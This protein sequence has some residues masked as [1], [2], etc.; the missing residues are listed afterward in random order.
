MEDGIWDASV[1]PGVRGCVWSME[2]CDDAHRVWIADRTMRSSMEKPVL[3]ETIVVETQ[4]PSQQPS[5][6]AVFNPLRYHHSGMDILRIYRIECQA[7]AFDS[8]MT[9][10]IRI[11]SN[12]PP[13]DSYRIE[14]T[15]IYVPSIRSES[16][17]APVDSDRIECG[18]YRFD[19][20][21]MPRFDRIRIE[22]DR[23]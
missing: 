11:E 6:I 18:F 1:R 4:V 10:R 16:N 23:A 7:L 8:N 2:R 9:R 5:P 17:V 20:Y 22:F 19:I 3:T 14:R 13:V 21:R 12:V 15:I